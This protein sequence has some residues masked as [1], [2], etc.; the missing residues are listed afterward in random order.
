MNTTFY[1]LLICQIVT[2]FA[3]AALRFALPLY[4]LR[5]TGSAALY[6]GITAAALVPMLAGTLYGGILADSCRKQTLLA[7]L[8]FI[9]ALGLLAAAICFRQIPSTAVVLGTLCLLYAAEGLFQPAVQASLPLL[10]LGPALTQGN[11]AIQLA[12]TIDELL[13]PLLGSLLLQAVGLRTLLIFCAV[14]LAATALFFQTLPIPQPTRQPPAAPGQRAAVGPLLRHDPQLFGMVGV[15]ALLN[16]AVVPAITVGVPILV[17]Q[18]LALPDRALAFT[19]SAMSAGGLL[20][21]VLAGA[22]AGRQHGRQK[23]LTLWCISAV[24]ALLGAAALPGVPSTVSYGA[25]TFLAFCQMA[26]AVPFQIDLVSSLQAQ[27]PAAQVGRCMSF[28]TFAICLTQPAGQALYGLAYDRF[29]AQPFLVPL[30]AAAASIAIN[31]AAARFFCNKG[32]F[33]KS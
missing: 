29:A 32:N 7:V 25:V 27:V 11:A 9:T 33:T 22:L 30:L 21:G 31:I 15:L 18:Y 8:N 10:L 1:R 4:L 20:G 14:C 12:D 5:K 13:G 23:M 6:G 16:L 3:N 2:L 26:A 24:C 17:I 19:Q 28:V